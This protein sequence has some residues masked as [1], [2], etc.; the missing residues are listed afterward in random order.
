M[1]MIDEVRT[2]EMIMWAHDIWHMTGAYGAC[3]WSPCAGEGLQGS[4]TLTRTLPVLYFD[5]PV[6]DPSIQFIFYIK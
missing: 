1:A 4:A 5:C 6:L 3:P 2:A